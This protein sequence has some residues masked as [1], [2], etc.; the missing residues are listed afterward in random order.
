L[1]ATD[2]VYLDLCKI[3]RPGYIS[4]VVM[5]T[6]LSGMTRLE[7][8]QL[9][10]LS[11]PFP[12][13][14]TSVRLPPLTRIVLPAL[15]SLK[16]KG[17]SEYLEDLVARIDV[18]LL[19]YFEITFFSQLIFDLPRICQFICR[20]EKLRELDRADIICSGN[21]IDLKFTPQIRTP[22]RP[23]LALRI[24]CNKSDWQVSS[25]AQACSSVL[26]SLSALDQLLIYEDPDSPPL[27]QDDMEDIQWLE[28][29]GPYTDVKKLF[30]S[31]GVG[32]RVAPALHKFTEE[33]VTGFLP[34]LQH[35]F[36]EWPRQAVPVSKPFRAFVGAR[37]LSDYPVDIRRWR[38]ITHQ[39]G[40]NKWDHSPSPYLAYKDLSKVLIPPA[41]RVSTSADMSTLSH[42]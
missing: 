16:F 15:I 6:C 35:L 38:A 1:S 26:P 33:R 11:P 36:L 2:L 5:V 41:P 40:K 18:P 28:L 20:S 31:E 30:L 21:S 7:Y 13:D 23:M 8:L 17:V 34:V 42:Q 32:Q 10:F 37:W 27:W 39:R 4:P 22:H 3:P 12:S 24:S 29:L 25:L 19:N 9:E 14:Q